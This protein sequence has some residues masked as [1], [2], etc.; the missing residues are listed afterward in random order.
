[1]VKAALKRPIT[2][3]VL[4]VGLL[5]FS[6][7]SLRTVP[8]D[9]FPSLNSPTVYVIQQYGG[10]S[11]QQMEGF[12][13]TKMQDHF[14]YVDG[15]KNIESKNIQGL[16]LIKLSF[17]EGTDMAEASAE[18]AIQVNRCLSFFP[19]GALPPEVVRF[20][21]SSLPIGE[22]VFSSKTKSLN[23]IF[24]MAGTIIRPLFGKV[25]G[26]SAPPAFGS[27]ARSIILKADPQ[28]LRE[29]NITPEQVVEAL[30]KNNAMTPSGNVRIDSTMYISS[31]NSQEEKVK[32]FAD[33]PIVSNGGHTIFVKDVAKVED[34]SDI[35][36]DYA[37]V[38]GK[39]SV[40]FPIVKTASASTWDVVQNLRKEIP[41]M[42]S[43]LGK[44]VHI[45]YEFDQS[46]FVMNS[47]KSLMTEGILGAVLTG[48]MVL[49][50]LR[51]WRSSLVVIITIPVAILS[52][53][54]C[55]KMAGQTINMMTLSGLALAIGILVDQATVTIENI[56]QHFEMGK[57]K[58]QAIQDACT[59]ISFPLLLIL[60]CI[61]AVFAPSFVMNGVPKAMFLP[62]SL[63]IAFAMIISY[64]AAQTLVPIMSNWI[65]KAEMYEYHHADF[66]AHAGLDLNKQEGEE[67]AL[68][69]EED[70]KHPE[71]ND[72][73]QRIKVGLL[74][75][76]NKWIP[77]RKPI[78]VFYLVVVLLL[79]ALG[80]VMIGKD[81]LPHSNA[82]QMQLRVREPDGTRL[83]ITERTVKKILSIVDSTVHGKVSISSA[84]VG[85]VSANYG[86]SNLYVFNSGS[87]EAVIQV[88][89]D[90]DFKADMD[91]LKDQ[92]RAAIRAKYPRVNLSFEPIE[93]TEKLMSQGSSTPVEVR[94]A[95][96][97]M[98]DLAAYSH[99]LVARLQ[100]I[101]YLR[102]VQ[103]AQPL[104]F[105]TINIKLDRQKLSQLGLSIDNV[106]KTISDVTASSRYTL[107]NLWL[108]KKKQY[109]Y[110][111]EVQ[112]PEYMMNNLEQLLATPIIP[113]KMR[114][115]LSDIATLT[116]DSVPGEYDRSGPRRFLTINANIYK[117]DLG[118]ATAAVQEAVDEM[119]T[120]PAG[121]VAQVKG[122]S[123]LLTETLDSLQN[124]LIA[125]IIVILL[126]LTANY[127]SFGLATSIISTVP[128]VL[129]GSIGML[130][131]TGSTL[132]LQSYMGII[133]SVGVSVSNA[134]LIVN[135]AESLRLEYRDPFK[136][137]TVAASI[138]LR[139]ILMTSMAMIAGMIPMASGLGESGDQSAPLGRAVIGGLITSTIAALYVVPLV[140]AWIQ[141]NASYK[142]V[143]MLADTELKNESQS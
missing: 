138:R 103:I 13:S 118:T 133:M 102:D 111:T 90:E 131:L 8:I 32:D 112:V 16:T 77:K 110:N 47:A 64:I 134:I 69:N 128:A 143:S 15:L 94:V 6:I 9:I 114:P 12:F 84:F 56:H 137:A 109:T 93:L 59:E 78:V 74:N 123:S 73:F 117:K 129:F 89:L 116:V 71:E 1:M 108:D 19:P 75:Q 54:F 121:L 141:Q 35:V 81:M 37:L 39:R 49:L 82:A 136:A 62:L 43:L 5:M 142:D 41:E 88:Q 83:E 14:L 97:D 107:K 95:A 66:H 106:S 4:F 21:A 76:L 140:Y 29:Y 115:L 57:S 139:P 36:V 31:V 52:T 100:K 61:L 50:F 33:I 10:M 79:T 91:V 72:F 51:D 85:P 63:S 42:Q 96:K 2:I 125:A 113:G 34:A 135:N 27:N 68:H 60:L 86:H 99:R 98:G 122:M 120:P 65:L 25:P 132:N 87:H 22:L 119:G 48:L 30:A 70:L 101:P 20:D 67:I 26:L 126:L 130:L 23:D 28:R 38:N 24:D 46:V 45:S 40:Y 18:I 104:K 127:Q 80:F 3:L 124:G 17:Y 105:P 55:L 58:K 7:L 11:A 53:V 92:I 44:D